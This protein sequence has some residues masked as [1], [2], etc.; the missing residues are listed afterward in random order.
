LVILAALC[1]SAVRLPAS[2]CAVASAPIGMSCHMDCCANKSCCIES[3]N[4]RHELPKLPLTQNTASHQQL[5][6]I[7]APCLTTRE[8]QFSNIEPSS[9]SS[10][11]QLMLS[12]PNPALLCTF[13]I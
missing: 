7:V 9:H 1:T 5:V 3:Q 2:E 8:F 12:A 10:A 11:T 4:G 6:A 13:L